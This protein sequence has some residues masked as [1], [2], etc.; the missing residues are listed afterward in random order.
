MAKTIRLLL[1]DDHAVVRT[2]YRAL[3]EQAA[4]IAIAGE[5]SSGEEGYKMFCEIGPDAVVMDITLPG[6]SGLET[7]RRIIARAPDARILMFSMHEDMVFVEQSL[8]AGAL[9]YIP[10]SSDPGILIEAI[11]TV[12]G[13]REFLAEGIASRRAVNRQKGQHRPFDDFSTREF[14]IFSLLA[15]G[16][17]T[18]A[19]GE[20]LCISSKTVANYT[21]QIKSK[22]QVKSNAELVHLAIRNGII[23]PTRD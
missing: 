11:N 9:G 21:T 1:V 3:L 20:K 17:T 4:G 18:A 19:V 16:N 8:Q 5:A 2:G 13:G 10:K 14:E 22:L 6:M 15:E 7:T 12:A 23:S